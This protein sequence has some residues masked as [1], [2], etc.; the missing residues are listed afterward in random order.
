[1]RLRAAWV[2]PFLLGVACSDD[3]AAPAAAVPGGPDAGATTMDSGTTEDGGTP[4]KEETKTDDPPPPAKPPARGDFTTFSPTGQRRV[5]GL[6]LLGDTLYLARFLD[7]DQGDQYGEPSLWTCSVKDDC[8]TLTQLTQ[9]DATLIRRS[10]WTIQRSGSELFVFA[11]NI[12]LHA[13]KHELLRIRPDGTITKIALGGV[14]PTEDIAGIAVLG[15]AALVDGEV[16][17]GKRQTLVSLVDGTKLAERTSD[18]NAPDYKSFSTPTRLLTTDRKN[19]TADSPLSVVNPTTGA[20]TT[21]LDGKVSV[22]VAFGE[23]VV[24]FDYTRTTATVP[25]GIF[26]CEAD[27]SCKAP[28]RGTNTNGFRPTL[29]IGPVGDELLFWGVDA[30]NAYIQSCTKTELLTAACAPTRIAPTAPKKDGGVYDAPITAYD[31][32]WLFYLATPYKIV[33]VRLSVP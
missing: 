21:Y 24:G 2:L 28:L 27:T 8:K 6:G 15:D 13:N 20:R 29:V 7:L 11:P 12:D 4:P 9:P 25:E 5:T 33:R 16:L 23:R 1:M 19:A 14:I 22:A 3:P 32:Q 26:A 31:T 30:A 17:A 18:G 10:P